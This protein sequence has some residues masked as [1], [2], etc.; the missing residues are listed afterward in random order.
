VKRTV[1]CDCILD[2]LRDGQLLER[3]LLFTV[4]QSMVCIPDI[5]FFRVPGPYHSSVVGPGSFPREARIGTGGQ[6]GTGGDFSGTTSVFHRK[7]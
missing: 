1:L 2:N 7:L 5:I 3:P 6:S 4:G